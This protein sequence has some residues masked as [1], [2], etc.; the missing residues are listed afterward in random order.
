MDQ[1]A[2]IGAL[3]VAVAQAEGILVGYLPGLAMRRIADLHPGEAKTDARDAAIIAEAA[4][5]MPHTLRS[6]EVA[7]EQDHRGGVLEGD[8]DSGGGI[9]RARTARDERDAGPPGHLAVG[10]GHIGDP[11]FLPADGDVDFRRVV[12]RIQYGEE[13]LARHGE[14]TVAA[15]DAELVDKDAAAG[16]CGHGARSSAAPG[17]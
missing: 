7:D 8:M 12:K 13:A 9:G 5:T 4:R 6:I 3:P 2:T 14:N 11:A 17:F 10:V 1:P 15:L 16:T